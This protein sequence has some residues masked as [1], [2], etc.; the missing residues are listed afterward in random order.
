MDLK[1][2]GGEF[3]ADG[4]FGLQ[5]KLVARESREDVGFTHARVA[6]E[7][8]FEKVIVLVIHSV[9]HFSSSSSILLP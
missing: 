3:D 6:D 5:A 1:R 9:R 4:G 8:D 2:P 7:D